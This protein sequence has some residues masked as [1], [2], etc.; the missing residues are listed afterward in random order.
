MTKNTKLKQF[1]S[2]KFMQKKLQVNYQD[3]IIL[4][5]E[6]VMQKKKALE[7]QHWLL[8]IFER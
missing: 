4:D 1:V 7:S 6:R 3:Y 5:F 8:Y 2:V